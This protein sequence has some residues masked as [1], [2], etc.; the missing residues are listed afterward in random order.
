[1]LLL[2]P[3]NPDTGEDGRNRQRARWTIDV[4]RW[5]VHHQPLMNILIRRARRP[6]TL[7]LT[8]IAASLCIF[9]NT[10]SA[11]PAERT[12][13][14]ES[15]DM[16]FDEGTCDFPLLAHAEMKVTMKTFLD[17]AGQPVRGIMTGPITVWF[18]NGHDGSTRRLSI[19]GPTFFDAA[20][21][22]VRGAGAWASFTTDGELVWAAGHLEVDEW[23]TIVSI[24]GT[25]RS[26][27]ELVA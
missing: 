19:P 13:I 3:G 24:Q 4:A 5:W 10:A 6:T 20:G 1:M 14:H 18:T 2:A 26:I 21:R 11:A 12:L 22:A 23:N 27:C 9:S 8:A 15:F 25:S 17:G 16:V 7:I